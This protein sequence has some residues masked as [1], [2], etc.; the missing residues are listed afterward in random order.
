VAAIE[1]ARGGSWIGEA[2]YKTAALLGADDAA[3]WSQ[4]QEQVVDEFLQREV[5]IGEIGH[6]KWK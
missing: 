1:N 5:D 3:F 2:V 4:A 6:E